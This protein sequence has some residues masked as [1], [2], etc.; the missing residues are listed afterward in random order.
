MA[1]SLVKRLKNA[2]GFR[3]S[4]LVD[5]QD[6]GKYILIEAKRYLPYDTIRYITHITKKFNGE[7]ISDSFMHEAWRIPKKEGLKVEI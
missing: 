5:I 6:N 1:D 2:L 7:M 4:L 3:V